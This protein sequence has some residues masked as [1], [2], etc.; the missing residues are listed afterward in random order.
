MAKVIMETFAALKLKILPANL[1]PVCENQ[2][3][4][5]YQNVPAWG[6]LSWIYLFGHLI[7]F[8]V[9]EF[10]EITGTLSVCAFMIINFDCVIE[11]GEIRGTF[12]VCEFMIINFDHV[13]LL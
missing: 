7:S 2:V 10:G 5:A 6:N 13:S 8:S 4:V 9:I 3:F 12:V 11:L 1:S